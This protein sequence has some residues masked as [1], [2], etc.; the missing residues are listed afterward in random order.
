MDK[1]LTSLFDISKAINS[2]LEIDQ[3][4]ETIM[5]AAITAIGVERGILFLKDGDGGLQAKVAR[6]VERETL[7]NATEISRSITAEVASSGKYVLSSNVMDDPK[8]MG[9]DSVKAFKILSILC[10][11]LADK[12]SII[13]TIY[14]DSRKITTTFTAQDVEFLQAFANLAAIAIQNARRYEATQNEARYWKDEAVGKYRYE[15]IISV[16]AQMRGVCDRIQSVAGTNVSILITGES[17][18]GKEL[19]ARAMH[20]ESPRRHKRFVPINCSALPEQ[21]L[22]AELFGAKKG[23]FTGAVADAKGL[24]EEADGGTIFLDEIADMQP[25]LQAKLLRVLQEGEIRRVGDTQYRFV[26]VRVISATNK[27]ITEA[28]RQGS[29]REDLYYRLCGMEVP[30]PPLRERPDDIVPLTM[31]FIKTFCAENNLSPKTPSPE[32]V[33]AL[34]QYPFPG[35]VRELQNIVRKAVILSGS[36]SAIE[37]FHLPAGSAVETDDELRGVIRRHIIETLESVNGNQSR[38]AEILGL[39]RTGLQAKMKKLNIPSR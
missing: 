37:D 23:A 15:N 20:Y 13:G 34:Q 29:F 32:A 8:I 31:H 18:T 5:D 12:E 27:D 25:A 3:L 39:S 26:N 30:I 24:F 9:R 7:E 2:V 17:G 33:A 38:A 36:P 14:L 35:N 11:P 1:T 22:E 10:V 19:V 28:I 16:S 21:I 6:N 4:L